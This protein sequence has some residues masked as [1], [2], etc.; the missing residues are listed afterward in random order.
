[1]A[2]IQKCEF[3]V[4]DE[5]N[6]WKNGQEFNL[7]SWITPT[8]RFMTISNLSGSVPIVK[9]I[10]NMTYYHS[11]RIQPDRFSG[12][13]VVVSFADDK[14]NVVL[15]SASCTVSG[16]PI[17][18]SKIKEQVFKSCMKFQYM[19]NMKKRKRDED[20]DEQFSWKEEEFLETGLDKI[21]D[22]K[23]DNSEKKEKEE[24]DQDFNHNDLNY[25]LKYIKNTKDYQWSFH[26]E[27]AK[28]QSC[29]DSMN[30]VTFYKENQE[31]LMNQE[32]SIDE[33]E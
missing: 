30:M 10:D 19:I 29:F 25:N 3:I 6:R 27:L 33:T 28:D 23:E 14:Q 26:I 31:N 32:N 24:Y 5:L 21:P 13:D 16:E 12:L 9:Y 11:Y 17:K 8:M 20:H 1:M 22:N 4:R 2:M 7:S 15:L 18:R